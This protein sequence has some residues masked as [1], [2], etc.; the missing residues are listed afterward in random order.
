MKKNQARA[1]NRVASD[2]AKQESVLDVELQ[3]T[4]SG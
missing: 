3:I 4:Q 1:P 2:A